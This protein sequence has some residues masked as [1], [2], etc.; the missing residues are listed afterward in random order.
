MH[1]QDI[2]KIRG[3]GAVLVT[4]KYSRYRERLVN[5]D[6]QTSHVSPL[7]LWVSGRA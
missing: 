5:E 1:V 3:K 7:L 4:V 6:L 2:S